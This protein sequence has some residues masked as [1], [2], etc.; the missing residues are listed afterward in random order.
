MKGLQ[1]R[2][3]SIAE[4]ISKACRISGRNPS[5][6]KIIAATK[7]I[8][9]I[10][11]ASLLQ[12]DITHFGEN[13]LQQAKPK[14]DTIGKKATWHFIGQLQRNKVKEVVQKFDYIHSVDRLSL[15]FHLDEVCRDAGKVQQCFM[16][17]NIAEEKSKGGFLCHEVVDAYERLMI[18]NNIRV[19]GLMTMAP[20][21]TDPENTRPIFRELDKIRSNISA[22]FETHHVLTELSMGMS[23]DFDVAIQEGATYVRLGRVLTSPE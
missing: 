21:F 1:N 12:Y 2:I 17:V 22:K 14:I 7:Y 16:Q 11:T 8:D 20:H 23:N 4:R 6:V 9:T 13:R 3:D 18:C 10:Q 19:I 15:A 5:E